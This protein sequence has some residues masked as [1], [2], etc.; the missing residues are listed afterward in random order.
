MR[1]SA[2]GAGAMAGARPAFGMSAPA[3]ELLAPW[4]IG[5]TSLRI[6]ALL[7]LAA[8]SAA[9]GD[10]GAEVDAGADSVVWGALSS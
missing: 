4:P 3:A 9:G 7:G 8:I 2:C 10:A 6:L 5:A 1:R